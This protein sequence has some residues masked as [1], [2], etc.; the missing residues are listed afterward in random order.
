MRFEIHES[1][2]RGMTVLQPDGD[3]NERSS[4]A[5]QEKIAEADTAAG[6]L[7]DEDATFHIACLLLRDTAYLQVGGPDDASQCYEHVVFEFV[8]GLLYHE[9][10]FR[11]ST[12]RAAG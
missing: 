9:W 5:L 4:E 1:V 3:L 7:T 12:V 11:L 8:H 6:I 10:G 2:E